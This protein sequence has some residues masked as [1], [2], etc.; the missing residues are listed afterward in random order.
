ML[1]AWSQRLGGSDTHHVTEQ[2]VDARQIFELLGVEAKSLDA[3]VAQP[4]HTPRS[5]DA[6]TERARP[7]PPQ[8]SGPRPTAHTMPY[9]NG[10]VAAKVRTET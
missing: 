3:D 5:W 1:E 4:V 7:S 8:R 2:P 10:T 6:A 9:A